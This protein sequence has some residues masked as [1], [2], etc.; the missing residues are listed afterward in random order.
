M[1]IINVSTARM[2]LARL[3]FGMLTCSVQLMT[4]TAPA[5]VVMAGTARNGTTE[6]TFHGTLI[7]AP[8]CV[9]NDGNPV[10]VDFGSDV[11][12]TRLDG[13]AY[14]TRIP[15]S[16]DCRGSVSTKQ[17]VR[18]SGGAADFDPLAL[19][20]DQAG[21]GIALFKGEGNSRYTPGEWLPFT[22][23]DVPELYAAPVKQDGVTLTGG[24]FS[25]LASLVVEYQ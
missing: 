8:P 17:K 6:V 3:I 11:M 9:I 5:D 18:I 19:S 21:F 24:A 16:L 13:T 10:V 7:E 12:T 20:G 14:K 23:P 2:L 22:D 4:G 1:R 15:L 25:I